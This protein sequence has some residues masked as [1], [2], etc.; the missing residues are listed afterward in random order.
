M[1]HQGLQLSFCYSAFPSRKNS[2]APVSFP[3]WTAETPRCRYLARSVLT[4]RGMYRSPASVK[5]LNLPAHVQVYQKMVTCAL[6]MRRFICETLIFLSYFSPLMNLGN[7]QFLIGFNLNVLRDP[8]CHKIKNWT[9][10]QGKR[11]CI[12]HNPHPYLL[13]P[14]YTVNR[15]YIATISKSSPS[16]LCFLPDFFLNLS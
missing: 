3:A 12:C 4:L 9:A 15:D 8:P 7:R 16:V 5:H 10:E 1:L 2:A 6:P 11:C 13:R 14:Y